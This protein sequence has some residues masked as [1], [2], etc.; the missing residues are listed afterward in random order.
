MWGFGWQILVRRTKN[1]FFSQ[2]FFADF[3]FILCSVDYFLN[4]HILVIKFGLIKESVNVLPIG[5]LMWFFNQQYRIIN[6]IFQ[7]FLTCDF[8]RFNIFW[9]LGTH[10]LHTVMTSRDLDNDITSYLN[11]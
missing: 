7:R 10:K 9:T 4:S 1:V 2:N 3:C 6:L 11:V 5:D 8:F